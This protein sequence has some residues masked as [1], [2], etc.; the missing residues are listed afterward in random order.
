MILSYVKH[1]PEKYIRNAEKRQPVAQINIGISLE[2]RAPA[3][4]TGEKDILGVSWS[5]PFF[6]SRCSQP[7]LILHAYHRMAE[8]LMLE[9]TSG[10]R[11]VQPPFSSR[12]H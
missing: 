4:M 3:A 11:L 5:P 2:R 6:Q 7:T 12:V 1:D 9:G 8:W 10:D